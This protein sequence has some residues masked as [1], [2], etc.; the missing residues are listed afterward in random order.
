MQESSRSSSTSP[1]QSPGGSSG[2]HLPG[3]AAASAQQ[4]AAHLQRS[5][6][7]SA[8][9]LRRSR[10]SAAAVGRLRAAKGRHLKRSLTALPG[11]E[12]PAVGPPGGSAGDDTGV[13][14]ESSSELHLGLR[15]GV[16][17]LTR[18]DTREARHQRAGPLPPVTLA[19]GA[20]RPDQPV[21][22]ALVTGQGQA[23]PAKP[24]LMT[25]A[26][27]ARSDADGAAVG[28]SKD[29]RAGA[30]ATDAASPA[31]SPL[32]ALERAAS[33]HAVQASAELQPQHSPSRPSV[34]RRLSKCR[35]GLHPAAALQ[36]PGHDGP[37]LKPFTEADGPLG[38]VMPPRSA[39]NPSALPATPKDKGQGASAA[40]SSS[41]NTFAARAELLSKLIA[42]VGVPRSQAQ[43]AGNPMLSRLAQLQEGGN[44]A[45]AGEQGAPPRE[46]CSAESAAPAQQVDQVPDP[47]SA[48]LAGALN[49]PTP[50]AKP[51][52]TPYSQEHASPSNNTSDVPAG[53][54]PFQGAQGGR[55]IS[56]MSRCAARGTSPLSEADD[57][58]V[59]ACVPST[60]TSRCTTPG[61][62]I[63]DFTPPHTAAH[64]KGKGGLP[65]DPSRYQASPPDVTRWDVF[66][67]VN[68]CRKARCF[69]ILHSLTGLLVQSETSCRKLITG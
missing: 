28:G 9:T 10:S 65:Y 67:T 42:Q 17:E 53:S 64:L 37:A 32:E 25:P 63:L 69:F 50:T 57:D 23:V 30:A 27:A 44:Q 38:Q 51:L 41:H 3:D 4:A 29:A 6:L 36:L 61:A 16:S 56:P 68:C 45:A 46:G 47:E 8:N 24:A 7:S 13:R 54:R 52:A 40:A 26:A 11:L 2:L 14:A 31:A 55:H 35:G 1:D 34:S 21:P 62:P 12:A 19:P 58:V 60:T 22:V 20:G 5:L 15:A 43:F 33:I 59:L 49:S 39:A 18:S 66:G 48:W